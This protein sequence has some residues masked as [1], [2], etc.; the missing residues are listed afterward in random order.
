VCRKGTAHALFSFITGNKVS[1]L[2]AEKT[3]KAGYIYNLPKLLTDPEILTL[4]VRAGEISGASFIIRAEDNSRIHGVVLS[5]SSRISFGNREFDGEECEIHFRVSASGLRDGESTEAQI[6]IRSNL[7][8]HILPVKINSIGAEGNG[9]FEGVSTL[10]DF[11]R[12]CQKNMREGFRLFTDPDFKSILNGNNRQ[13]LALYRGMSRNPVTYQH[14]EEFLIATGKKKP[15][16]ITIDRQ[17]KAVYHLDVSQKD[18]LFVYRSTWGYV[19]LEV[20]VEGEF[21]EVEKKVITGDDF[22]GKV[23][24]LEYIVHR[25][26]LGEG[27]SFGKIRIRSAHQT[28]EYQIEASAKGESEIRP[29]AVRQKRIA[30]LMRDFLN[31]QLHVLDY[32]SWAESS[33]LTLGEMLEEDPHDIWAILYSAY[34]EYTRENYSK[35]IEILWPIKD[36]TVRVHDEEQRGLYLYIAK[37]VELLP[38]EKTNILGALKK[39]YMRRPDSYL[40]LRLIHDEEDLSLMASADL[41]QEYEDCYL[42]GC[43]SPFLYLDAWQLLASEEA[44][45]RRL[46]PFMIHLLSFGSKN[47]QITRGLLQRTAFLCGNQKT[48]NPLLFKLLKKGYETYAD[49]DILEAICK[50]AIKGDPVD[51]S[52]FRWYSDAVERDIRVTRLYEYYME[53][54]HQPAEKELPLPI[55]MY[56]ATNNTLGSTKK[57][58]LYASIVL[59]Q[60]EDETSYINY[61]KTMREF[62]LDALKKKKIND[63]YAV[64]YKQFFIPPRDAETAAL[65]SE[66]LFMRKVKVS[67]PAVRRVIVSGTALKEEESAPVREGIAYVKMYNDS[68]SVIFEDVNQRRYAS[69][70]P[71][72]MDKLFEERESAKAIL[73]YG[74]DDPG[75]ELSVCHEKAFQMDVNADTVTAYRLASR[76]ENFTDGYRRIIRRKL[77]EYDLAHPDVELNSGDMTSSELDAFAEADR[78]ST[79]TV[80]IRGQHYDDAFEVVSRYGSEGVEAGLLKDM[81]VRLIRL[82]RHLGNPAMV[83]AAWKVYQER[84]GGKDLLIYLRDHYDGPVSNL[85]QLWKSL[86]SEGVRATELEETILLRCIETHQYPDH[87][88]EILR[89]CRR[90]GG[91]RQVTDAYMVYLSDCYFL[92]HRATPDRIFIALEGDIRNGG[93]NYSV[94]KL[95]LLKY[96]SELSTLSGSRKVLAARLLREMDAKGYRFAFLK[97]LP[98]ELIQAYQIDDK[99]FVEAQ[100]SPDAHVTIHYRL[101]EAGSEGAGWITEPM[102]NVYEGIF[103]KEFLLFYGET[104]TY[105]LSIT[106]DSGTENTENYEIS[107]GNMETEGTTKYSLLNRML[108]A[109]DTNDTR[110][111]RSSLDLYMK[112]QAYVDRLLEVI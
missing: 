29:Q 85:T 54:Y 50:I 10:D 102:R 72:Q 66:V 84:P 19:R 61:A 58:L 11:S 35:A 107:L 87:E 62:A 59:H 37:H 86:S 52:N 9:I 97:K 25:E 23:Y 40:L 88:T 15:V 55:K 106:T 34:L 108:Q 78:V 5:D 43:T 32:P 92:G 77:L 94:C 39:Y 73:E 26:R 90:R 56:F 27:R 22:I 49:N 67:D 46:S 80:L 38:K 36:G 1:I 111:L 98:K 82:G 47:G 69:T 79:I 53:T 104:L 6:L 45:L 68:E 14:L 75:A 63:D 109:R 95:A 31:L 65:L 24:G 91:R 96:Y 28:L 44:L 2:S 51:P 110:K 76:N 81:V 8:E 70:I 101:S 100:S 74:V 41:M 64:L 42:A 13:Y 83:S 17:E 105:Y 112:Q 30:W 57:A 7:S 48:F 99:V 89:S 33:S 60:K 103:S 93:L 71:Y 3:V 20:E 4:E 18:T 21:L 12:L 16:E